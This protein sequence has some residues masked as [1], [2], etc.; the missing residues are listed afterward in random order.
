MKKRLLPTLLACLTALVL[1][2]FTTGTSFATDCGA[3]NYYFNP[4]QHTAI[5]C[6][7]AAGNTDS[8]LT[9]PATVTYGDEIYSVT[10]IENVAFSGDSDITA[11]TVEKGITTIG[12][13][14]FASCSNPAQITLP[15]SVTNINKSSFQGTAYFDNENNWE[16]SV[17]YIGNC[18]IAGREDI[19]E[20][21]VKDGTVA[22]ADYAFEASEEK[23]LTSVTIPA[24]V[25]RIGNYAFFRCG[26]LETVSFA[27]NSCL[28]TIAANAFSECR[29]LSAIDLPACVDTIESGAFSYT[30]LTSAALPEGLKILA[31]SLFSG[32]GSLREVTIPSTV[33]EIGYYAFDGCPL[34]TIHFRGT[35]AQ[36][37][38]ITGDGKPELTPAD[39]GK[40]DA[41]LRLSIYKND[42]WDD[43]DAPAYVTSAFINGK[44]TRTAQVPVGETATITITPAAGYMVNSVTVNGAPF[45]SGIDF[46]SWTDQ[47]TGLHTV[48]FTPQSGETYTFSAAL[49]EAVRV[50]YDLNGGTPGSSWA[51]DTFL[52]STG[53]VVSSI[54]YEFEGIT[55]PD[56]C[57][58]DGVEITDGNGNYTVAA[59]KIDSTPYKYD[60]DVT[61]KY[62]WKPELTKTAVPTGKTLTYTGKAQTGVAAGT[63]YTLSGTTSATNVGSYQA[64]ATLSEGYVWSDETTAAKTISWKINKA[65][66]NVTAPTG[67]TLTYNGKAQ[68][69]VASG[70]NYTLT[71]TAKATKAGSYTAKATLKTNANYTYKWSDGTTAAK[72][73]SWKINKAAQTVTVKTAYTKTFGNAAFSLGAKTNGDGTLKYASSKTT[74]ATVSTAGKVTIKGAGTA[75]ITVYATAGTNYNKSANKT[76]TITVNKA[77]NPLTVKAATATVKYSAL[78]T[79]NQTLGVTKVITFSKKG[80]GTMTYTKASGNAKI[81]INKTTGKVTV[82]KGLKKGT[83]KVKLTAKAAGNANYKASTVKTVTSTIVVK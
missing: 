58:L 70:A 25:V 7:R 55:P 12:S 13:S 41:S 40:A 44:D 14:A 76:V 19:S 80:Q 75:K 69:G 29:S 64:T 1:L 32:C 83:Y 20:C 45:P 60:S 71:G 72:T 56:G 11:L 17:L 78:K 51:G 34:E 37:A 57:V 15:D 73:I 53:S 81:V 43:A 48:T 28:K 9:I 27:E 74:V 18:L 67:K 36:W 82:K 16:N 39:Y 23:A 4:N 66:A 30:G 6:G 49:H 62:I 46:R 24:S 79:A 63:G 8:E 3:L 33:T 47:E 77:A 42:S 52:M 65:T 31:R 2:P 10:E 50:T 26:S 54:G 61:F 5:V 38:D 21:V 68:I 22:I 59:A 35:P